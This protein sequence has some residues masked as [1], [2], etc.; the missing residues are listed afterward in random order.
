[1]L[2]FFLI[3][4]AYATVLLRFIKYFG[5]H[6]FIYMNFLIKE[7]TLV[8]VQNIFIKDLKIIEGL[9]ILGFKI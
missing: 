3:I 8:L 2:R 6:K 5:I 4:N 1:M 9:R 7:F